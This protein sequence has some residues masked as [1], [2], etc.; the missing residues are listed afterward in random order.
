M[1]FTLILIDSLSLWV[2]QK[3]LKETQLTWKL[4]HRNITW[5]LWLFHIWV[6]HRLVSISAACCS[7]CR[8]RR[9]EPLPHPAGTHARPAPAPRPSPGSEHRGRSPDEN[10]R[11][12]SVTQSTE[13]TPMLQAPIALIS[14]INISVDV[15]VIHPN[16]GKMQFDAVTWA[17]TL[18]MNVHLQTVL[19]WQYRLSA[20]FGH[21]APKMHR[22]QQ[23]DC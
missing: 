10:H 22:Q 17:G 1:C 23:L 15:T 9:T 4:L 19:H 14:V 8:L 3:Q 12:T 21:L 2:R 6:N 7:P 13:S 18:Q 5:I 16:T 20:V 11:P